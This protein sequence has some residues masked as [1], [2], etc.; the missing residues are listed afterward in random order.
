[1]SSDP[2]SST[3]PI[4]PPGRM[5][6][7]DISDLSGS[8]VQIAGGSITTNIHIHQPAAPA[9]A[10]DEPQA[11]GD[12]PYKGLEYFD[13]S[14]AHLFF[15]RA[16]LTAELV[17]RLQFPAAGGPAR[18]EEEA[19]ARFLAVVG[20]SGSG[21][22]SLVRAG[23]IPALRGGALDGS[24]RWPVH[25][26][27]PTATPLKELAATLTRDVESVTATTTLMDDLARDPRSLDLAVTRTLKRGSGAA[28]LVLIVD[29]FEELFTACKDE[30]ERRAFVDSLLAAA[31]AAGPAI[32]VIAL[33]ADFYAHCAQYAGL[34]AALET[35]QAYIGPMDADD[36]RQA[37][38]EPARQGGWELEPG[39]V[40][41]L[42][43]DVGDEPG[44]LPLLSHA[45]LETWRRRRGRT[46][47]LAGYRAAG[48]V[49]GAIAQSAD[50]VYAQLAP[51]HQA[52]AQ[53]IFLRLTEPGEGTQDTRRRVALD[54]LLPG[55]AEPGVRAVLHT[56]AG[57]RLVTIGENAA[58]VAH[59]AL[60]REWPAL[61]RWLDDNREWLRAHRRLAQDAA[62]WEEL[63]RDAGALYR[64][65]ELLQAAQWAA[66]RPGDLRPREREFLET[67]QAEA[68]REAAA[69]EAQRT[70]ELEAARKL[71]AAER[72][73][74][75][76]F[77]GAAAVS[78][79]LLLLS[80][81]AAFQANASAQRAAD[82]ARRIRID[83]LA[84]LATS[85]LAR[86]YDLA[87]LLSV[88]SSA[89]LDTYGTRSAL[90]DGIVYNPIFSHMRRLTGHTNSVYSVAFSPDGK[91]L[92]SGGLDDTVI[93]WD[94]AKHQPIGQTL[95]GHT[96][97][98][99][100]VAFSPDGKTLASAS[101]DQTIILWDATADRPIGRPLAGHTGA[102][103]SVAFSPDGKTLASGSLDK[104]II[105][106]NVATRQPIGR[107]LTG[108][109]RAV[110]SVAFSPDGKTLVS[111]SDDGAIILWDLS[112]GQPIG[113]P[114]VSG[115]GMVWS[116]AFSPDGKTLAFGGQTG[117]V[118]LW[119][120]TTRQMIGGPLTGHKGA[121]RSVAFSP[122][123]TTLASGSW[124]DTIMLW[125]V[126]TR[127]PIGQPLTGYT[128]GMA[129]SPDGKTL[130]SGCSDN[131]VILWDL[132]VRQAID[133]PLTGHTGP[134]YSV[135]FSPGGKTLASGSWD[136]SVVLWNT[137]T[138]QVSGRLVDSHA[139]AV[140]TVAFSPDG[141]TL[142]S[143]GF[144]N[145]VTLWDV[146]TR[147]PI[148]A[149]LAG[150]TGPVWNVAFSPDGKTLASGSED[151]TIILWDVATRQP[152]GQP[153]T[154]HTSF[155]LS[156][157]FSPD[158]K[159]LASGSEDNTI[160]LW[161]VATHQPI[162]RP[163]TGHTSFVNSVAFSP[164]GKTLA[165]G[166]YDTTIILW[167]VATHQPIGAPLAG[168][169]GPVWSVA[170]SPECDSPP[171][172]CGKML[173]SGSFGNSIILWDVAERQPIG[174]PLTGHTDAVY[175]VVFSP[176]GKALASGSWDNAIMLWD[177]DPAAWRARACDI[178][179]R[180]FTAAE[181]AQYFPEETYRSTCPQWPAP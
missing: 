174:P 98:V 18:P 128:S 51:E 156:V 12:P 117:S 13:E 130:A 65:A 44:A 80:I 105:V 138:R 103:Y 160:M 70:R 131:S 1:M 54:E 89:R 69:R 96:N 68:A 83:E 63:G 171:A 126:A 31:Q 62:R 3:P 178:V 90:L 7:G 115:A 162:G 145:T 180:N 15:G 91:T 134:V 10:A 173:A 141:K 53:R 2:P 28:R 67:A 120:V 61:R 119:D 45:L 155:V 46:L 66:L 142:A 167:D 86:Q 110:R 82:Q 8:Q 50:R 114:F 74:G 27:T 108:H 172:G 25:V 112:T 93:R 49:K 60:I 116:V 149:P 165:S 88:E 148:G 58:E 113:E 150:H 81:W 159:T 139:T 163:L 84:A 6:I 161:D 32:V 87:L 153:L 104:T 34:R 123:G 16:G 40:E 101:D 71:A 124:D 21:K 26:I 14:D 179:G 136:S 77:V 24:A 52:I 176:D 38:A 23:L 43:D 175:N 177:V 79:L 85:S 22:S 111:G 127:L 125:V 168:H 97:A 78:T 41:L 37:I 102:V 152:I 19:E 9:P 36:L 166:S 137:A 30:A 129:F 107:P 4:K 146:A 95:T 35:R 132:T 157:A 17:A 94:V 72:Q 20:A 164:D 143:G 181:W 73:R 29:Q 75:R 154:G 39:L 5:D 147:Q 118:V 135:A 48:G 100:S 57:A 122:D 11:P 47:T 42:L 109:T 59:E 76:V 133:Q 64:G 56:L 106:W 99:E 170:F 55:A 33:R 144:D 92:A 169:T 121:V 151:K 158:G 140:N